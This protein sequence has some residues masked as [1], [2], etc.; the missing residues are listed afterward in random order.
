MVVV[1]GS[2]RE[3]MVQ[4]YE[5]YVFFFF[6]SSRRRHTRCREVS[7]ARRCVQE[8]GTNS[9]YSQNK[10]GAFGGGIYF[11]N[12]GAISLTYVTV[13]NNI[14]G[15]ASTTNTDG[16]GVYVNRGTLNMINTIVAQ[17][18]KGSTGVDNHNDLYLGS[19]ASVGS[20]T[21]SIIGNSSQT[22][23][24]WDSS[25]I[26]YNRDF[27]DWS[28]VGLDT[29]L[30]DNGGKTLTVYVLDGSLA[31]QGATVDPSVTV[32]QRGYARTANPTIG[33][34]EK[35]PVDLYY[36]GTDN[37]YTNVANWRVGSVTGDVYTGE[38]DFSKQPDFTYYITEGLDMGT[39]AQNWEVTYKSSMVINAITLTVAE[40]TTLSAR[41][42]SMLGTLL[43]N[44]SWIGFGDSAVDGTI[45]V[46]ATGM[47]S[48]LTA[49]HSATLTMNNGSTLNLNTAN[50]TVDSGSLTRTSG[51][52]TLVTYRSDDDQTVINMVN[53]YYNLY[54]QGVSAGSTTTKTIGFDLVVDNDFTVSQVQTVT[55]SGDLTLSGGIA[56]TGASFIFNGTGG[57]QTLNAV[58]NPFTVSSITLA[59]ADG[60]NVAN[61][62]VNTGSFT[63]DQTMNGLVTIGNGDFT[64]TGDINNMQGGDGT[65]VARRYFVT[66]G[67]GNLVRNIAA[68]ATSDFVLGVWDNTLNDYK[69]SD[70][71]LTN[72]S[73]SAYDAKALLINNVAG[74]TGDN[75]TGLL[76]YT[77][78]ID[79]GNKSFEFKANGYSDNAR[80]KYFDMGAAVF[81]WG[82]DGST[83]WNTLAYGDWHGGDYAGDYYYV[84]HGVS[85]VVNNQ[86]SGAGSLRQAVY[87]INSQKSGVVV[88]D[89]NS[90]IFTG[91]SGANVVL[92]SGS[93]VIDNNVYVSVFG[94]DPATFV[95]GTN[96]TYANGT[97]FVVGAI[98]GTNST[99]AFK[100]LTLIT[101]SIT[102]PA[103]INNEALTL[104]NV[105]VRTGGAASVENNVSVNVTN[106]LSLNNS[107]T[108]N[109]FVYASD[110]TLN[111]I[112][113]LSVTSN[114]AEF[115]T[116]TGG[117]INLTI[118][119]NA[120]VTLDGSFGNENAA[121]ILGQL[122]VASGSALAVNVDFTV[123]GNVAVGGSLALDADTTLTLKGVDNTLGT[124]TA[125]ANS[126]VFY[127]GASAQ[128][129]DAVEY[130]NL[131]VGNAGITLKSGAT[132]VVNGTLY[133]TG[134][135]TAGSA[136]LELKGNANT[137]GNF[138]YGLSLIHI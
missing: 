72:D 84:G 35:T 77:W 64:V 65:L 130:Y 38:L 107:A 87:N 125:G 49:N 97:V 103:I 10:S 19:L 6:F 108:G 68:G 106:T 55:A 81:H 46:A 43:V 128:N 54:L 138:V 14:S 62:V 12:A 41:L 123:N 75:A 98:D 110:T 30:S 79:S 121:S 8:T 80:G 47:L 31:Y 114:S 18:Y 51:A 39:L 94:L 34:Y 83:N 96:V 71:S 23:G 99:V 48:L 15:T 40:N 111:Y 122:T 112:G 3:V 113:N 42:S 118:S 134:T 45:T 17:N 133:S 36:V 102:A 104:D 2:C 91:D 132:T 59:N 109:G 105:T 5:F 56:A 126:T 60:L 28:Q 33:A 86:D 95:N 52:H 4:D 67:N 21:Y 93:L 76:T 57:A 22:T 53:G 44:G 100:D 66:S 124:F 11:S 58:I 26:V 119:N 136:R 120:Q 127:N 24:S 88:F 89:E 90:A 16:G 129:A 63:F 85:M 13:A 20:V 117:V 50:Y 69:W 7:W 37:N 61:S 70:F 78:K 115:T 32:D 74:V 137:F 73:G 27:F 1:I 29:V 135:I 92:T 116:G 9:T 25:N 101:G 82:V 131:S